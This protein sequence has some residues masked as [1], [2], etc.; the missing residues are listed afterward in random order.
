MNEEKEYFIAMVIFVRGH[1]D[2]RLYSLVNHFMIEY[3]FL[4]ILL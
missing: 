1:P 3:L 4:L 2:A